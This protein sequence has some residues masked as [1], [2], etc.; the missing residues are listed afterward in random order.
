LTGDQVSHSCP[1][2][3]GRGI[4][5]MAKG[6]RRHKVWRKRRFPHAI[7][8]CFASRW[9]LFLGTWMRRR[10]LMSEACRCA[11]ALKQSA[12]GDEVAVEC[13]V[14]R[15]FRLRVGHSAFRASRQHIFRQPAYASSGCRVFPLTDNLQCW[16]SRRR[17]EALISRSVARRRGRRSMSQRSRSGGLRTGDG[18]MKVS[19]KNHAADASVSG[20]QGTW[21]A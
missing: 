16:R 19:G 3:K 15:R 7:Q 18:V 6:S 21:V 17:K 13:G 9:R 12:P 10:L 1:G 20:C 8:R 5:R 14:K 2:A 4:R 11:D